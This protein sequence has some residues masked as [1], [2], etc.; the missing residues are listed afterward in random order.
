MTNIYK[1]M[2]ISTKK[3]QLRPQFKVMT[4][5]MQSLSPIFHRE[6]RNYNKFFEAVENFFLWVPV[7]FK[8]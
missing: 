7:I 6:F 4:D 8:V 1:N 5:F 2:L 3:I